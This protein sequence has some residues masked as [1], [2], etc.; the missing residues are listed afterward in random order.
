MRQPVIAAGLLSGARAAAND[1][2]GTTGRAR[3]GSN[4]LGLWVRWRQGLRTSARRRAGE[5]GR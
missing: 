4:A 5:E 2:D 3:Q 1:R